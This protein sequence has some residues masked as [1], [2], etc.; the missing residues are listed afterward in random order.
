MSDVA[1]ETPSDRTAFWRGTAVGF[2]GTL[3]LA[4]AYLAVTLSRTAM[5]YEELATDVPWLTRAVLS[6]GWR[7]GSTAILLTAIGIL[8][9]NRQVRGRW[10]VGVTVLAAVLVCTTWY[11][12][13]LPLYQLADAIR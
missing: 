7:W 12:A 6:A 11:L 5:M 1:Y 4:Q 13:R 8:A 2:A 9:I 3:A 10:C